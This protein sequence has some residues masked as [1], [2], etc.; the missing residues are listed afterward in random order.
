MSKKFHLLVYSKVN[1]C[2]SR[3][4]TKKIIYNFF[5]LN[6]VPIVPKIL[7]FSKDREIIIK[8]GGGLRVALLPPISVG[9]LIFINL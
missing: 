3:K 2:I 9:N 1:I 5:I 7:T 6:G 8:G 4:G